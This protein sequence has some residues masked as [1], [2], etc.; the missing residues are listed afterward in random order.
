LTTLPSGSS[1]AVPCRP[2]DT[3]VRRQTPDAA[4]RRVEHLE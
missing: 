1:V 3:V 4:R 2:R